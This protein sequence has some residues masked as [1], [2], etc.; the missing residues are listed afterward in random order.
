MRANAPVLK[1][2][3]KA[4]ATILVTVPLAWTFVLFLGD[5]HER[6]GGRTAI[7]L[8]KAE[9]PLKTGQSLTIPLPADSVPYRA[10]AVRFH[11]AEAGR[12]TLRLC[13][14]SSCTDQAIEVRDDDVAVLA[15]PAD[16]IASTR[17]LSL[18]ATAISGGPISL[19]GDSATPAVEVIQGYSWRLPARRARE[20]FQALAGSDLFPS[21]L[22][23][24]AVALAA[25][26]A[27]CLVLAFRNSG[28]EDTGAPVSSA[29]GRVGPEGATRPEDLGL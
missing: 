21:A 20:V 3:A 29:T 25:A 11:A 22:V 6:P 7:Q 4:A 27:T 17:A 26:F 28:N 24:C 9:W 5:L 2:A 12:T 10:V 8:A 23:G 15:V 13:A 19:R 1:V 16:A 14:A 18:T